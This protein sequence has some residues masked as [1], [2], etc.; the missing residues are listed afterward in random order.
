MSRIGR[1][2][3]LIPS[4]VTVTREADGTIVVKGSKGELRYLPMSIVNIEITDTEIRVTRDGEERQKRAA[5]GLVRSLI[6]N[7][8]KGV[9]EG[10]TKRLE[11]NGVGYRAQMQGNTLVLSL[12]YSHPVEYKQPEGIVIKMDEEKKNTII[13]VH[14]A[15]KQRV[16]QVAAEIRGFRK[17]EPYKGKGIKYDDERI[18]RKAGKTASK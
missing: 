13:I 6:A 7:M 16:G 1:N 8:V 18:R 14:G 3:V 11:I 15:D 12:G 9:T 17:P 10:F 4:G 2:P 5:H